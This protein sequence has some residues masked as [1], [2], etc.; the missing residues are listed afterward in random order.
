[1]ERVNQWKQ[2]KHPMLRFSTE[3]SHEQLKSQGEIE[4]VSLIKENTEKMMN[5]VTRGI[6]KM[7]SAMMWVSRR[8]LTSFLYLLILRI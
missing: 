5:V 7:M 8:P 1:M 3:R 4:Q 2:E 6:M